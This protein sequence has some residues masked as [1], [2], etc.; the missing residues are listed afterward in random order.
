[1]LMLCVFVAVKA[2]KLAIRHFTMYWR[3]KYWG[4]GTIPTNMLKQN[5]LIQWFHFTQAQRSEITAAKMEE[6]IRTDIPSIVQRG[7]L[8]ILK[9][10][11]HIGMLVVLLIYTFTAPLLGTPFCTAGLVY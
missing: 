3:T 6:H 10:L 11:Q 8:G 9:L 1:M 7:F 4:V 5:M 2:M